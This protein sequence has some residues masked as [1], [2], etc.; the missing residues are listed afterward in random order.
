[1]NEQRC[2]GSTDSNFIH[3]ENNHN[4]SSYFLLPFLFILLIFP[5]F[6][7][8]TTFIHE[9]SGLHRAGWMKGFFCCCCSCN[10]LHFLSSASYLMMCR[11]CLHFSFP[12]LSFYKLWHSR[13]N[14]IS[15]K[16]DARIIY[17]ISWCSCEFLLENWHLELKV[18]R[19]K[20]WVL[21][22]S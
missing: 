21:L 13:S 14:C 7:P 22:N 19:G 4:D 10:S 18:Q 16:L 8:Y 17:A 5:R 20:S 15:L 9:T 2:Y 6:H 11:S 3:F 1:M 12:N